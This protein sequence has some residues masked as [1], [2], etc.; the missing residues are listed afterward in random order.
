MSAAAT[1][2]RKTILAELAAYGSEVTQPTLLL[3]VQ[4]RL[5]K[6]T[7]ADLRAELTWLRDRELAVSTDDTFEPENRDARIWAITKAGELALKK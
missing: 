5:P 4:Q 1:I 6:I 2:L 3:L 7:L